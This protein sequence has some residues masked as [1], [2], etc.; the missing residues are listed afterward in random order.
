M[1]GTIWWLVFIAI[2][3][4]PKLTWKRVSMRYY[5]YQVWLRSMSKEDC[6]HEVHGSGKAQPTVSSTVPRAEDPELC[7]GRETRM[8]TSKQPKQ[9][10][11]R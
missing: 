2:L 1:R 3:T 9:E 10:K 7:K 4:N 11:L 6:F 5:L 8:S